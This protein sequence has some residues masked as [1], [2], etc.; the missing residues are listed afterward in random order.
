MTFPRFSTGTKRHIH[1]IKG[2]K[3]YSQN[4]DGSPHDGS[5]GSPPKSVRD[6]LK[7]KGIWDWDENERGYFFANAYTDPKTGLLV[8]TTPYPND[9]SS[10]YGQLFFLPTDYYCICPTFQFGFDIGLSYAYIL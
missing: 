7:D 9:Y 1:I 2:T 8:G 4:I 3:Y 10:N 6:Y 5:T